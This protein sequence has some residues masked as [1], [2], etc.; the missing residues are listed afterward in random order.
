MNKLAECLVE[1]DGKANSP[2]GSRV[3]KLIGEVLLLASCAQTG[4]AKRGSMS[5]VKVNPHYSVC[6]PVRFH[7]H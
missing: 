1:A 7:L 4:A 3:K 2:A 5:M 6:R